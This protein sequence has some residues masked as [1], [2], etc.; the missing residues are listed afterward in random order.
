MIIGIVGSRSINDYSL[1]SSV[2][3]NID[4]QELYI[5]N[6]TGIDNVVSKYAINKNIKCTIL[7]ADDILTNSDHIIAFW[8]GISKGTKHLI[9]KCQKLHKMVTIVT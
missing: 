4:I 7:N 6:K 3:D 1:V 5:G 8:D 9:K 2:L